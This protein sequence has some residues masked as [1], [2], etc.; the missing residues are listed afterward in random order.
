M[1]VDFADFNNDAFPD[2]ISMDMLPQDPLILKSSAAEDPYDVYNFKLNFGYHHQF[3]RNALQLN[4][5]DGSFSE[6]GLMAGVA[7][8]DWSWSALWADVDLDGHK[9]IL[10]SN[11]IVRRPNDLDYINFI[12]SDSIQTKLEKLSPDELAYIEKMPQIKLA[13]YLFANNGDSTFMDKAAAWGLDRPSYSNGAAYADLDNDGD[14]DLVMNNIEDEAFVY[15]NR[16]IVET[17]KPVAHYVQFLLK[18]KSGNLS[19][20]GTKVFVYNQGGVQV[21]EC[22]PTRGFQ[23]AVD[24]RLTFGLGA[25]TS[26]DSAVIVWTDGAYQKLKNVKGDQKIV[27]RQENASGTFNYAV[28]RL[29]TP[30]FRSASEDLAIPFKHSENNFVEFNREALIPHMMSREGPASAVGDVNGD[31]RDDIFLGGGKLQ[32]AKVFVQDSRGKFVDLPQQQLKED[33]I[34]EDVDAMFFDADG[35]KDLDLV[36][37]SGGNEFSGKSKYG[38]P[39]LYFNSGKGAFLRS[40]NFLNIFLTGSCVSAAD[41]DDDGDVDLFLGA[42]TTPWRYGVKADSYILV[43]DGKGNFKNGTEQVAP[44]LKE[45]GFV[46]GATWADMNGDNKQ[47]LVVAAEWSPITVLLNKDGRL[48]PLTV[49]GSGLEKSSGWWNVVEAGDFDKDGD[50]DLVAGNLGLNS[51]LQASPDQQVKMYVGDFDQ[52]DSIDQVLT[53]MVRDVEY[54]FSTRDEMTKQMPFLKKK[55]LSYRKFANAS[56]SDMFDNEEL[57]DALQYAVQTFESAYIENLGSNKFRIRAL[58]K[59]AQFSTVNAVLI[60]DFDGD[61]NLDALLGGNFHHPNIQMGRYDA[62]LGLLLKGDGRGNFDVLPN[63]K[64]GLRITGQVRGLKSIKVGNRTFYL[65]VRNNQPVQTFTLN[66]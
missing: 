26:V 42:R 7:A 20:L 65:A 64:S 60:E 57:A 29:A 21:Q 44:S 24:T 49:Q 18:G 38:N 59:G 17:E 13:N 22:M 6:I 41:F 31:G 5:G 34:Y 51:K 45:F 1:G 36:V 37:V 9:D 54:P 30:L 47:D 53:H 50:I 2:L 19:G 4:N 35:D 58:P 23:S 15:E 11:G 56:V 55:Y 33:S 16:T 25:S 27:V 28:F 12:S 3:A 10:V 48:V 61:G 40:S 46:K 39:R 66:Q 14:L 32:P 52:N 43:N 8:S 63:A 62:S